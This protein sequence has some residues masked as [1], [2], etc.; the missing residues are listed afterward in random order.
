VRQCY[1]DGGEGQ[2]R[3]RRELSELCSDSRPVLLHR[4]PAQHAKQMSR[5]PW[6]SPDRCF[7][8]SF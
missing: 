1:E 7:D 4:V 2:G 3:G 5:R 8:A 6:A